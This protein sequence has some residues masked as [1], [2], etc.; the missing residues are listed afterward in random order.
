MAGMNASMTKLNGAIE[1]KLSSL[2]KSVSTKE[3]NEIHS[4]VKEAKGLLDTL[5]TIHEG[6][7]EDCEYD[8][9]QEYDETGQ[10][11]LDCFIQACHLIVGMHTL[12]DDHKVKETNSEWVLDEAREFMDGAREMFGYRVPPL[13]VMRIVSKAK[14]KKKAS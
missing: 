8:P 2:T 13:P 1:Q 14:Q 12:I 3:L 6:P 7:A 4:F 11:L 5:T 9:G 10:V